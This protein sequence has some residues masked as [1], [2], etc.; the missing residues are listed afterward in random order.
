VDI[1]DGDIQG[2]IKVFKD[3]TVQKAQKSPVADNIVSITLSEELVPN[4]S[5]SILSVF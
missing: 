4:T 5:Y 1:T 2:D 3:L